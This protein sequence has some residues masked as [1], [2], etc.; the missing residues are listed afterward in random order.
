MTEIVVTQ[1]AL[2]L[3]MFFKVL[4]LLNTT[5]LSIINVIIINIGA[6]IIKTTVKK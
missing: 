1:I 4:S 5:F 6:V 3:I 2:I